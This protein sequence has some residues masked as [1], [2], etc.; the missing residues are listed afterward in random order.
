MR[1]FGTTQLFTLN[2][3]WKDLDTKLGLYA[4]PTIK[5]SIVVDNAAQTNYTCPDIVKKSSQYIVNMLY[6][7]H[8]MVLPD[9]D[10]DHRCWWCHMK[11]TTRPLGCPLRVVNK[12]DAESYYSFVNKKELQVPDP[13]IEELYYVTTGIFCCHNCQLA[14]AESRKHD[15]AFKE[16]VSLIYKMAKELGSISSNTD[17]ITPSPSYTLLKE[18]GGPYTPQE[19]HNTLLTKVIPQNN[20]HIPMISSG[21]I[22]KVKTSF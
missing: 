14:Y 11:F 18:Y 9:K 5:Q 12:T 15:P 21:E 16:S 19:Y 10:N 2:V 7:E 6:P 13:G 4:V 1:R 8:K 20:F 3:D 22:Y 17:V